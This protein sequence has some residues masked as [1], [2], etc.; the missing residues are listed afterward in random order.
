MKTKIALAA[1]ATL[2]AGSAFAQGSTEIYGR[3]NLTIER[4]KAGDVTQT[5]MLNNSSRIG[6]RGTED[7][8]GGLKAGF[9]IEHGFSADT[10]AASRPS[11]AGSPR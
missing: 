7:L 1:L 6:F 11:G 10:G 5:E 9:V 4:Q 8:G 3:L 2:A